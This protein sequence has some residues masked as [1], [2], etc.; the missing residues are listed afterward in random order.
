[1]ASWEE[2]MGDDDDFGD[3]GAELDLVAGMGTSEIVG[4]GDEDDVGADEDLLH[5][6]SIGAVRR[7]SHKRASALRRAAQKL[8]EYRKIDPG[9]VAIKQRE[10][11]KRRRFPLGFQPTTVLAGATSN[12]PA[13][14]QDMFRP[15]RLVIP[16]DI[17]FDFGVQDVKV[18]NTSQL[19]SGGEVPAALFTE[20]SIDTHVHFKTAEIGNQISVSVR[21][22]TTGDIEFSAGII[23]TVVQA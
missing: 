6:L 11:S 15:E 14:P 19:V 13:A 20:V 10:L 12:I 7:G 5:A 4:A 2:I 3:I 8:T 22:K 23:G 21:N 18:G 17:A 16:S 9:A 1:M